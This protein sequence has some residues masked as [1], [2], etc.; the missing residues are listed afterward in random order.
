MQAGHLRLQI[1]EILTLATIGRD[2]NFALRSLISNNIINM[3]VILY[4]SILFK[5][6]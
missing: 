6:K 4:R 5:K 3:L 1:G 2:I